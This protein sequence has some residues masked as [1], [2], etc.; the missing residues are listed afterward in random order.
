MMEYLWQI[1]T[2]IK[3]VVRD[4]IT[5]QGLPNAVIHV[6]NV[7]R[8]NDTHVRDDHINHDVTS[9]RWRCWGKGRGHRER[10]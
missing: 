8:I 5:Q 10:S 2:G 3:G 9:G 4:A 7:T 1:H 6:K